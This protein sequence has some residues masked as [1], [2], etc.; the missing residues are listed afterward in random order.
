MLMRSLRNNLHYQRLVQ[1][2]KTLPKA[3]DWN[4][5]NIAYLMVETAVLKYIF[6]FTF[7][8]E[9]II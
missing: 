3:N 7:L 6:R 5:G 9:N 4:L 1:I 2:P 8:F